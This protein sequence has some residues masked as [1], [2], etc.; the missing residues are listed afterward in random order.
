MQESESIN[1]VDCLKGATP[2]AQRKSS[3]TIMLAMRVLCMVAIMTTFG[4][5]IHAPVIN[6]DQFVS[7]AGEYTAVFCIAFSLRYFI[8]NRVVAGIVRRSPLSNMQGTKK[9]M[10]V[11][12][13][14]ILIMVPLMSLVGMSLSNGLLNFTAYDYFVALPLTLLVAYLVNFAFVGP[15]VKL[16]FFNHLGP[17]LLAYNLK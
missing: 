10:L 3:N 13:I 15:L 11:T 4:W 7:R 9:N 12:A 14:N 17:R 6:L 5:I 8:V 2:V 1:Y 16:M